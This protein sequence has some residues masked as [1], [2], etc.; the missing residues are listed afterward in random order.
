MRNGG[1][2]SSNH[3]WRVR[4]VGLVIAAA[5]LAGCSSTETA[6]PAAD[7][8]T[9]TTSTAPGVPLVASFDMDVDYDTTRPTSCPIDS[10]TFTDTSEG[11]PTAWE[12]KFPDDTTSTEQSPVFTRTDT[13]FDGYEVTLTI[14]R[15]DETDS[16]TEAIPQKAC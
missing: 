6:T 3:H 11:D 7:G 5:V 14:T 9:T 10:V 4:T 12:W 8:S 1:S 16:A 15:G 13:G 2:T